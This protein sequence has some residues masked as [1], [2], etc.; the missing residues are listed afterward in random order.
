MSAR[1]ADETYAEYCVRRVV[2]HYHNK[3]RARGRLFWDSSK[4]GTYRRPKPVSAI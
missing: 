4:K 2:Q 1:K 3:L